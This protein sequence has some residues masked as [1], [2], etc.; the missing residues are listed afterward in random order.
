MTWH[1]ARH[2][3]DRARRA[4]RAPKHRRCAAAIRISAVSA[5]ALCIAAPSLAQ[6]DP[7][8]GAEQENTAATRRSDPLSAGA[9]TVVN[10]FD[11][12]NYG[13]TDADD[14]ADELAASDDDV[15]DDDVDDG[16]RRYVIRRDRPRRRFF[17]FPGLS[18]LSQGRPYFTG[19]VSLVGVSD[20]D[21][22]GPSATFAGSPTVDLDFGLGFGGAAGW[23]L[24]QG[25]RAEFELSYFRAELATIGPV[26]ATGDLSGL[27]G[28][29][30]FAYDFNFDAM[31]RLYPTLGFG[32]GLSTLNSKLT[33]IGGAPVPAGLSTSSD[34]AFSYQVIGGLGFAITDNVMLVGDYRYFA[35]SDPDFGPYEAEVGIH[36][37]SVSVRYLF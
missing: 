28:M 30:N 21:F 11:D 29:V 18:D 33:A 27:S 25:L 8:E 34:W 3:P 13:D 5:I 19:T 35:T 9:D 15:A 22:S 24:D 36:K 14:A 26:S 6:V 4:W 32:L 10:P 16:E 12:E 7:P 23:A 1:I 2:Q 31:P 37:F 20:S 17:G